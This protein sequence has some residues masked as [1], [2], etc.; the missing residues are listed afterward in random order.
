MNNADDKLPIPVFEQII[1]ANQLR[2]GYWLKAPDINKDG[3]YDLFGYGFSLGELTR[4]RV[5]NESVAR[6][7]V[8]DFNQNGKL[9]F[10]TIA[11]SVPNYFVA[12]QAR[13]VLHLNQIKWDV[14][15]GD[16]HEA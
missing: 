12:K 1:V 14:T 16:A 3:L 6:I 11:Y 13:I 7:A 10:A 8:A 15:S 4:W 2:D 9:D 5:S